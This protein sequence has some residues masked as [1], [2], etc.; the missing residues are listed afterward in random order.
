VTTRRGLVLG[1]GGMLGAAWMVGALVALEEVH[2]VPVGDFDIVVGTSAGSVL[3]ALVGAGVSPRQ[4]YDHQ[5]GLT[6]DEG[7]LAGY[8]WDY[9]AAAGGS[10]PVVP[11][12]GPGSAKMLASNLSRARSMPPT[13]LLSGL[14]PEGRGSL[15]RIGHLVEA[16]TPAGE[17]SQHP[18]VWIVTMDYETGRRVPFGQ[19]GSPPASLAEAVM[20][21]CAIPAWYAP[22]EINGH[23]YVDGGTCSA[24]S[25]DLLADEGLDEVFVIA[26]MVSFALDSPNTLVTRLER[27]WRVQVTKRC[28]TEA[29]KVHRAGADVTVLGPGPEDLEAMGANLM[30]GS[31]RLDVLE[32]SVQTS[33]AALAQ[34][35]HHEPMR[36]GRRLG[37]A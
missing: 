17:W 12:F 29:A 22:V 23:R 20:A 6:V 8:W 7:P 36:V 2:G 11:R 21:S 13:A 24:T 26:P 18:G 30:D 32:T 4:L 27:R 15:A 5:L 3:T 37:T 35:D 14:L 1:G 10:R 31:R 33:K 16:V 28:L 19:P 9:D 25:V 34:P